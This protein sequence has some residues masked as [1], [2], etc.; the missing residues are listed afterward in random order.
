MALSATLSHL[1]VAFADGTVLLLRNPNQ[2]SSPKPRTIHESPEEP[3]TGLGFKEPSIDDDDNDANLHLFIVTTNMVVSYQVS[4]KGN[5]VN[6]AAIVVN[7]VGCAL[8]CATMGWNA[9]H[10]VVAKDEAIYVCGTDGRGTCYA[11]EG[12]KSSIVTHLNYLVIVSPPLMPSTSAAS[13]TVRKFA[14]HHTT[15]DVDI[16]KVTVFD[17]ENK[18]V[19]YSGAFTQGVK[20]VISAWGHIYV[21][22]SDGN[23]VCLRERSTSDKLDMLYRKSLYLLALNLA[24]AQRL[25]SSNVAD[26]HRQYGSHLYNKGDYDGAMQQFVKTIGHVQPSYVIRKWAVP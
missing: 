16:T 21:L 20:Q 13:A 23:L 5:T 8:G 1:A 19:A 22:C 11:Y 17:M 3:V 2:S 14:A 4:G 9:Q 6:P 7:E 26:I 15:G 24:K 10:I 18:L 25:D 12:Y